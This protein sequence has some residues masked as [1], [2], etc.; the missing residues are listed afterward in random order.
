MC[1]FLVAVFGYCY[2]NQKYGFGIPCALNE[3]LS[4]YCP[5]CGLTRATESIL[6]LDFYQAFRYHTLSLVL[7]PMFFVICVFALFEF[8]F[9]KKSFLD[10]IPSALWC[11]LVALLLIYGAIRNFIPYLQPCDVK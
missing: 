4:I 11:Y 5:G 2:V 9:N 1:V 6:K 10:K 3:L 8:T 7:I